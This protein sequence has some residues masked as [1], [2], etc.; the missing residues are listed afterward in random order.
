[1]SGNDFCACRSNTGV[2]RIVEGRVDGFEGGGRQLCC[3]GVRAHL[4]PHAQTCA[5]ES[6]AVTK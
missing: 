2:G 1:M 4:F 6:R 3:G 5:A